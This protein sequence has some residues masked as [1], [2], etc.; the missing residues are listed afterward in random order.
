MHT[1][2]RASLFLMEQLFA[3][4]V[5]AVCAAVCAFIF[6][7]AAAT[8]GDARDL[9]HATIAAKNAAEAYK[10][11]GDLAEVAALLGGRALDSGEAIIYYDQ[12]WRPCPEEAAIYSLRLGTTSLTVSKMGSGEIIAFPVVVREA[13]MK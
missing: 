10:A 8:A 5:F 3:I 7:E 13:T 2:T 12:D 11:S 6:T 4:C 9:N 1:R